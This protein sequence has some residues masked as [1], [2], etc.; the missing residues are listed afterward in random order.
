MKEGYKYTISLLKKKNCLELQV[1]YG[2]NKS[3]TIQV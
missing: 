3:Q 2:L 1:E